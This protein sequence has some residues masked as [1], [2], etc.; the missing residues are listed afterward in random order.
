MNCLRLSVYILL[1]ILPLTLPAQQFGGNPPS[2][3]WQQINTDTA[4]I[5]FPRGL[6]QEA[7]QVAA[8]VHQLSRTT[9]GTIGGHLQKI[10]I[11]LQNQTTIAN[12]YVALAPF[13]SEFQ[14]TPEQNSLE[15]GSLPWQKLLA[16]H[17]YRHVQQ[18]TNFRIGL[19]RAFYYLFGEEGQAF[20]NSL[21]IPN[22]FWEGDAVYQETLVSD[23]GRGRLPFF[24]NSYR[25][26]WGGGKDYSWMKLRNGS[27]RDYVP[28]HYPLGYMLVSYGRE[29]YG[30]AFWKHTTLDAASFRGLFY[31]L[32]KGISRWAGIP[33]SQF[34]RDALSHFRDSIG[35]KDLSASDEYARM[36][37]HFAADQQFPQLIGQDS[38]LYLR[39][40]YKRVPA[41]VIR[42]ESTGK[43][44]TFRARAISNDDYQSYGDGKIVYAA[45]ETDPRWNWR[46]YSVIRVLDLSTGTDKRLT[47]R[48][49]YFAPSLSPD[50]RQIVTVQEG[51][52]GS[53]ALHLLNSVTGLLEQQ[54][55]NR[56]SLF[57]TYPKFYRKDTI[58]SAV[59]NARG[60]MSLVL[61]SAKD[62]G[63]DYL[64]P[65]S[66]QPIAYPAVRQ[67]TIWFTA[68]R[69]GEDRIYG[70][71]DGALF[72]VRLPHG[73]PSG[74]DYS[75]QASDGRYA[76]S[77]FTAVGYRLDTASRA[78]V[79][80]EPIDK[81]SWNLSL[82][83]QGI[84]SLNSGPAHLLDKIRAGDYAVTKYPPGFHIL[85]FHSWRPY[86]SDP[87]YTFSLVSEN[88]LNTLESEIY[89]TYNRN[90]GYKQVGA[91]AT[92]GALFPW[93]DGGV[94]YTFDRNAYYGP[95]KIFWNEAEARLGGSIPLQFTRG[96]SYTSLQF[97]SD[98][99]YNKRYFQG[100][101]K[102]SFNSQAFA[103]IDPY[104]NFT[105]Q[106]QQTQ[107]QINPRLAQVVQLSYS[108]AVTA[109]Q[110]D[111]FL[112][113]GMFYLPGVAYT[114]SLMLAVAFQQRDSLTNARF[115]NNFPF[116]RGYSAENFYRMWRWSAN[117]SLPLVYPDWGLGNVIYF[118]RIRANCF[119][120][121]TKALDFFPDG[122]P[123]NAMYRSY[124]TEVYF[125]TKWWNQLPISFG[126]RY[127]HLIDPDAEGRGP[128]QWELILPLNILAQ[129]YSGRAVRPLD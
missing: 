51:T 46:D 33:F 16:I 47:S 114:H 70:Y 68:S 11:V 36:H 90:E 110:A 13:R 83:V 40:T 8:I 116:S 102:D 57:F 37:R 21:A 6:D 93:I 105:H 64:L 95:R 94:D 38:L 118:L 1:L 119:Y 108:R 84:D 50:G 120:D 121:Y 17:E 107:Q 20:T 41:F 99:V 27:L 30:D 10:N 73:Q 87:D 98:L 82:P 75:F 26:L 2:L 62:G 74:G 60:E 55:P 106:V 129:G 18:Y 39:S 56:D 5:I 15:L 86:I 123:F 96:Q 117:Y 49:K 69:N 19:S 23:Q 127:S 128:N 29:H 88:I 3:H 34:R 112:A 53:C 111:Q 42:D 76:W 14:L 58:L 125:D 104:L 79:R 24:F 100:I 126:I 52:D 25:S 48:T 78:Q 44:K 89:G 81:A 85:H 80:L 103:Y 115:T 12:G 61:L 92:Y 22:W 101:Y 67:D 63:V 43:E 91:D 65:W 35:M 113:S 4:R 54:I 97:G 45:Y 71:A 7:Q 9:V 122:S 66:F 31:P 72:R 59:R 109:L 32:Q 124:G 28:D 77:T